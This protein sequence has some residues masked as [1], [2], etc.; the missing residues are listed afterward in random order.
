M[1]MIR[2]LIVAL[3]LASPS[4]A[5]EHYVNTVQDQQG[6]AIP[7]TQISVYLRRQQPC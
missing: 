6:S 3:A 7:G 1:R 5:M 4:W 2:V